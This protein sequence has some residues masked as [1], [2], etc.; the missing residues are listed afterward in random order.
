MSDCL[1]C[2]YAAGE[3]NVCKIFENQTVLIFDDDR[4]HPVSAPMHLLAISKRH[5]STAAPFTQEDQ[6]VIGE[7][8]W[9]VNQLVN[10][11]GLTAD[12]VTV[13]GLVG[14]KRGF[15]QNHLHLHVEYGVPLQEILDHAGQR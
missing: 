12:G 5:I 7:I 10:D 13:R 15:D 6:R 11:L 3:A 14:K 4:P 2:K 1:F 9:A 8:F